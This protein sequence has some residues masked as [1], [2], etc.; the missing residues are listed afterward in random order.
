MP[1]VYQLRRLLPKSLRKRFVDNL[2]KQKL[3]NVKFKNEV[4]L[5]EVV[6]ILY[7][8]VTPEGRNFWSVVCL[9]NLHGHTIPDIEK[10]MTD[11]EYINIC[12]E[13]MGMSPLKGDK[14]LKKQ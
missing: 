2:I 8:D 3:V 9:M 14:N 13:I 12:R 7:W 6:Q 11:F 10:G 1:T 4:S 5:P